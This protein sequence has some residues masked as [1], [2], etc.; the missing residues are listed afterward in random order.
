[1]SSSKWTAADLPD[2]SGRTFTSELDRRLTEA[3]SPVRALV[4]RSAA[5]Q[6]ERTA[7]QL[8]DMSEELT[9]VSFPPLPAAAT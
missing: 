7:R 8:W 4:G 2:Q 1:M 5:A 6:D 9:G 3:G